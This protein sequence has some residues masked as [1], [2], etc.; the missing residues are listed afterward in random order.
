MGVD[1]EPYEQRW[2]EK[3]NFVWKCVG[4]FLSFLALTAVAQLR[5]DWIVAVLG[6]ATLLSA[7]SIWASLQDRLEFRR[8]NRLW[9]MNRRRI[10]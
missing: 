9:W 3:T 2:R 4:L 6:G 5:P 10:D 8:E 7:W 1:W